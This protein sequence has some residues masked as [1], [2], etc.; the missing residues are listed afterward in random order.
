MIPKSE[1][2]TTSAT[3]TDMTSNMNMEYVSTIVSINTRTTD[4]IAIEEMANTTSHDRNV[5][6]GRL[7]ITIAC[8]IVLTMMLFCANW[9]LKGHT[10][11]LKLRSRMKCLSQDPEH[12]PP[13]YKVPRRNSEAPHRFNGLFIFN[14]GNANN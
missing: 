6:I 3:F 12:V 10:K 14:M 9:L 1:T 8:M 7:Y 5:V 4:N 13:M 11:L 2:N